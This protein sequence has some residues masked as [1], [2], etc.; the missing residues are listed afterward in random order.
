MG[1]VEQVSKQILTCLL[2]DFQE[3]N[4]G[5]ES[6]NHSYVGASLSDVKQK[7]LDADNTTTTVDFDLALKG[8]EKAGQVGTGPKVP[9]ENPPN[10]PV[11][12]MSLISKR[13][14]LYLTAKG[15]QAAR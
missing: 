5:A 4:L 15:Y 2:R 9:Y 6:L 7:C 3:R 1:K 10:S 13:E 12:V 8:L 14:Y 11:F